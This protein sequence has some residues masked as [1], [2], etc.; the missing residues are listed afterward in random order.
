MNSY[1]NFENDDKIQIQ[2]ENENYIE[3][4][5]SNNENGKSNGVSSNNI[6]EYIELKDRISNVI[7]R[8][9]NDNKLYIQSLKLTLIE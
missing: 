6:S 9:R 4:E 3:N 5:L 8:L 2:N 7:N 1:F